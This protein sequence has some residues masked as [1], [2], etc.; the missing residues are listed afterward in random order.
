[1]AGG[2]WKDAVAKLCAEFDVELPED[3]RPLNAEEQKELDGYQAYEAACR[4]VVESKQS[5]AVAARIAAYGWSQRTLR[6][7]GVGT[8]ASGERFVKALVKQGYSKDFLAE[9]GLV[10]HR[11]FRPECLIYTVR[12]GQGRPCPFEDSA[13]RKRGVRYRPGSGW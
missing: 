6:L 3:G 2:A 10:D 12:D 11:M 9:I 8:A 5:E 4:M 13:N 7:F 1:M